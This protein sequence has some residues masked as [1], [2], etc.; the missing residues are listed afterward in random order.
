[1]IMSTAM[2]KFYASRV[3]RGRMTLDEVPE[4]YRQAVEEYL[5]GL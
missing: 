5:A 1:M 3:L 4:K 2:V